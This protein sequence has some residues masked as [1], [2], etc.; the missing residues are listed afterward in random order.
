MPTLV[1]GQLT[2]R[3]GIRDGAIGF[4]PTLASANESDGVDT[5]DEKDDAVRCGK[6]TEN[7]GVFGLLFP[8]AADER[9]L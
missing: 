9:A 2:Q 6:V 1:V 3:K 8:S 4:A 7:N 5:K